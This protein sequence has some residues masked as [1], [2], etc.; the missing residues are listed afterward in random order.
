MRNT[1]SKE[2]SNIYDQLV[3]FQNREIDGNLSDD[4]HLLQTLKD[5]SKIIIN[6]TLEDTKTLS[7][8]TKEV[9]TMRLDVENS[10]ASLDKI[11]NETHILNTTGEYCLPVQV[12][13]KKPINEEM[14]DEFVKQVI[15]KNM[16]DFERSFITKDVT[17]NNI[18]SPYQFEEIFVES[19]DL[20]SDHYIPPIIGSEEFFS[21]KI[22]H[23]LSDT[24]TNIHD[25]P[26]ISQTK[27]LD[28]SKLKHDNSCA[29]ASEQSAIK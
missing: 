25:Q 5:L 28:I 17:W 16:G 27:K 6:Q 24:L 10:F 15:M 20:F 4:L 7:D 11:A 19:R 3:V 23:M 13:E 21:D 22:F 9:E 2:Y 12:S 18:S 14:N 26:T 29:D 8:S 1:F